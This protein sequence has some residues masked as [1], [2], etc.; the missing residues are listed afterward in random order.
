MAL[1]DQIGRARAVYTWGLAKNTGKT[2]ALRQ[3]L[4]EVVRGHRALGVTSMGRDGEEFDAVDERIKKPRLLLPAGALVATAEQLLARYDCDVELVERTRFSCPLGAI[5][6]VRMRRADMLEVAGPSSAASTAEIVA[7][8]H[9]A[10]AE[11]VLIDGALDRRAGASPA[12]SDGV[13]LSTGAVLGH[14]LQQVIEKTHFAV[15]RL[16][17]SP[18][19][20]PALAAAARDTRGSFVRGSRGDLV[21]LRAN[22]LAGAQEELRSLRAAGLVPSSVFVRGALVEELVDAVLA[23]FP[24]QAIEFVV[25]DFT[26][27]FVSREAWRRYHARGAVFD[28]LWPVNLLAITIN[29]QAPF[30]HQFESQAFR[31]ALAEA[32]G[33]VSVFDVMSAAY[34]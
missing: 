7:A 27:L 8:M 26:C 15:E 33:G 31:D 13:V 6:L 2:V 21:P 28:V 9:R 29:P 22:L 25:R 18:V 10:G 20:D 32:V 16:R 11:A 34:A 3:L 14:D 12:V 19:A 4:E 5:L 24:D 30:S 17:L 1:I 23:V